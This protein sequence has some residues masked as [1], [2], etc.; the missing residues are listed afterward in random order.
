[1]FLPI[2]HTAETSR[3]PWV[4]YGL[5]GLNAAVFGLELSAAHEDSIM[6]FALRPDRPVFY[7]FLTHGFLHADILHLVGNMIF[8]WVFGNAV[9]DRLGQWKY[10]ASYLGLI[11]LSGSVFL[12]LGQDAPVVGAS[13]AICGVVAMFLVLLAGT[14]IRIFLMFGFLMKV[15]EIGAFWVIGFWVLSDLAGMIFLNDVSMVAYAAHVGGYLFGGILAVLLAKAGWVE[16]TDD[17]LF[18]LMNPRRV[19]PYKA[20][21]RILSA[22][23]VEDGPAPKNQA[24]YDPLNTPVP[25]RTVPPPQR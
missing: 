15:V 22:Q 2:G 6:R 16:A 24:L 8:L 3:T 12:A 18:H 1:M 21:G 13:G 14:Q 4:N 11:V 20:N 10:L 19:A 5:I 23:V 7:Q 25:R 17:D 9:N